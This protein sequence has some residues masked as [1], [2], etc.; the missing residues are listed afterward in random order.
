MEPES[1]VPTNRWANIHI[2]VAE[3]R[4]LELAYRRSL[5]EGRDVALEMIEESFQEGREAREQ[6]LVEQFE[7]TPDMPADELDF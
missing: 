5:A 6:E 7:L 1:V 3:L 2:F 4:R